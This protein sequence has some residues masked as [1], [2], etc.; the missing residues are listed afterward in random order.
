M[1][2]G[3][4]RCLGL[5][6]G[7]MLKWGPRFPPVIAALGGD[8]H[9]IPPSLPHFLFFYL[10]G[11]EGCQHLEILHSSPRAKGK[12]QAFAQASSHTTHLSLASI[13]LKCKSPT[14][15]F[16]LLLFKLF[17]W[18]V[19][20]SHRLGSGAASALSGWVPDFG[21]VLALSQVASLVEVMTTADKRVPATVHGAVY[22]RHC[23]KI[24]D[25]HIWSS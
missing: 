16:L 22:A 19:G 25:D 7:R 18:W 24:C 23:A 20:R 14:L 21:I 2:K 17:P 4:L 10:G 1:L 12:P 8:D 13:Y 15:Y 9:P 6:A 3:C 5:G 11:R